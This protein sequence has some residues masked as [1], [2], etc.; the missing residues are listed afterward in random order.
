MLILHVSLEIVFPREPL[1]TDAAHERLL[2]CVSVQVAAPLGFVQEWFGTER[3]RVIGRAS[4]GLVFPRGL[5]RGPP[6]YAS[7]LGASDGILAFPFGYP[8]HHLH[9]APELAIL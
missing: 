5:G 4:P 7:V 1:S 2:P 3:A 6:T 8:H 9:S